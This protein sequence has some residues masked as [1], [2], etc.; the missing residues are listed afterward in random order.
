MS[1]DPSLLPVL[2]PEQLNQQ[3]PFSTQGYI[4]LN[5]KHRGSLCAIEKLA[6]R[7]AW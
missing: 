1:G 6:E 7:R 5:L 2:L 3:Y 4:H